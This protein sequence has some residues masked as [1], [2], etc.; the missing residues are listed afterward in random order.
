MF[1]NVLVT[2]S[3]LRQKGLI[4]EAEVI[5]EDYLKKIKVNKDA[6]LYAIELYGATANIK[7]AT[8]AIDS[9]AHYFPVDSLILNQ[10]F[11]IS[12]NA[13]LWKNKTLLDSANNAYKSKKYT[14]AIR[15]YSELFVKEPTIYVILN[16]RALC[17][18]F[19]KE[20]AKSIKDIEF[21]ISI[22]FKVPNSYNFYNLLGSN[23]YMLGK[24][25]EACSNF[26]IAAEMGDKDGLDNYAKVCQSGKK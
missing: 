8:A 26:K 1:K 23:Y 10:K 9:A 21:L 6:W 18:Y 24:I 7:K 14:E 19:V 3:L 4:K 11:A 20:Y 13:I 22:K 17:Y 2:S 25:D 16:D 12:Q 5:I 15:L